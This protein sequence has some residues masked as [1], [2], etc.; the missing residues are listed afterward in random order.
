LIASASLIIVI[1]NNSDNLYGTVTRPY[2]YKVASQA[3]I[4]IMLLLCIY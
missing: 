4:E 2:R 1:S 3:T